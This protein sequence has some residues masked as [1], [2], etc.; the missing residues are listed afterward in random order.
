MTP[1]SPASAL[2]LAAAPPERHKHPRGGARPAPVAEVPM[3][4]SEAQFTDSVVA[5]AR[6]HGWLVMHIRPARTGRKYRGKDGKE[7]ETWNTP[8]QGDAGFMDLFLAHP[9]SGKVQA[10]E[11]KMPGNKPTKAQQAWLDAMEAAGIPAEVLYP[12]DYDD[13]IAY[14]A[15]GAKP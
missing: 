10:W 3:F 4:T 11:L 5:H 6:A 15:K 8:Y 7:R 1:R 12:K 9:L 2:R 13:A 14:L